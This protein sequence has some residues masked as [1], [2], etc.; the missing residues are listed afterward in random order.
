MTKK[1]IRFLSRTSKRVRAKIAKHEQSGLPCGCHICQK[2]IRQ[3]ARC[4]DALQGGES[5]P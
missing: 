4:D 2:L 1:T 5:K 3:L